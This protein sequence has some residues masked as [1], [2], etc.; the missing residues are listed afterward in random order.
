MKTSSV[1]GQQGSMWLFYSYAIF[2]L[3]YINF[4]FSQINGEFRV[5]LHFTT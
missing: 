4:N 2:Y 5:K 1:H 3:S